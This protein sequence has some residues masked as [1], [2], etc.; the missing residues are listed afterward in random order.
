[1]NWWQKLFSKKS[2]AEAGEESASPR[3]KAGEGEQRGGVGNLTPSDE[4]RAAHTSDSPPSPV[5][6]GVNPSPYDAFISYASPDLALAEELH[7]RLTA[8]G[9]NIWFDKRRLEPGMD[10]HREIEAG[11]ENSL[12]M[13]PVL[14]PHWRRSLWT[15]YETYAHRAMI[16]L[17][18][19][20]AQADVMTPPLSRWQA[21]VI[22]LSRPDA[23]AWDRLVALLR[24]KRD[25]VLNSP[26]QRSQPILNT[27]HPPNPH[28]VGRE[29]AMNEMIEALFRSPTTAIT[30]GRTEA[31]TALGGVGKTTLANEFAH[32]YW[33]LYDQIFWVDCRRSF[34]TQFADIARQ[35]D[36]SIPTD[37]AKDTDAAL[38][39]VELLKDPNCRES[40]LLVLDNVEDDAQLKFSIPVA[41]PATGQATH[42]TGSWL[43]LTG[44]CHTIITS[45]FAHWTGAIET[46]KLDVLSP[47]SSHKL[48][49]SRAG[50]D[51]AHLSD[52]ER[53][54]CEA[55]ARCLGYLPLALEVAGTYIR[56]Q[57]PGFGFT[58]YLEF[59]HRSQALALKHHEKGFTDYPEPVY[60]TQRIT[61][62]KLSPEAQALL[63][64]CS[65]LSATPTHTS[66]P[67]SATMRAS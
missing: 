7:R 28:F 19:S 57:G 31:I 6:P 14:T 40:R 21:D 39:A 24:A 35:L 56:R 2:S 54:A 67:P 43:P 47:E 66:K 49:I 5:T 11:C 18:C 20:G 58:Q 4:R 26:R 46:L 16:P 55:L 12:V 41:D 53:T 13:L 59:Y 65:F 63:R 9:F 60:T 50:L 44:S 8:A 30:Q 61:I 1:M 62:A 23:H 34:I 38:R 25:A 37:P 52:A 33:R 27:G 51:A 22:D 15:A 32:R 17:L 29:S 3:T 45:R 10:W 64:L 36:R 42:R 48:L